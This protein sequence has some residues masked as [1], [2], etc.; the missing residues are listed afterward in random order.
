MR[1]IK[2]PLV[3]TT[4]ALVLALSF[5]A[6][7]DDGGDGDDNASDDTSSESTDAS[8]D[9]TEA[10]DS[11]TDDGSDSGTTGTDASTAEFCAGITNIITVS[12]AVTGEE[13]TEAEWTTIQEA[14]ADL[15]EIGP[16]DDIPA[17]EKEGFDIAIE[18]ITSLSY[19]EAEAA[20][21]DEDGSDDIPG[22]SPEENAKAEA[23]FAWAGTACPELGGG[24]ATE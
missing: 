2:R 7:G 15:G 11:G 21:G 6:C 16:P 12:G 5:A 9:E 10:T 4:A 20:F 23:F 13:P 24:A 1:S 8:A 17:E 14:Y 19:A 22:V 18:A 3:A